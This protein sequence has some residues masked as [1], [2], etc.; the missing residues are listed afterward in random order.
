MWQ[1]DFALDTDHAEADCPV[2][3]DHAKGSLSAALRGQTEDA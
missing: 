1:P 3:S 2:Q